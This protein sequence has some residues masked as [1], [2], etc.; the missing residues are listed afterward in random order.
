MFFGFFLVLFRFFSVFFL[1]LI[2]LI[3]LD[4]VYVYK[5]FGMVSGLLFCF[6][7]LWLLKFLML[8]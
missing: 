2:L 6:N 8:R 4:N 7:M 1:F 5:E 3:L